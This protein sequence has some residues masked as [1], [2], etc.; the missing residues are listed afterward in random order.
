MVS[1]TRKTSG[2][3]EQEKKA[4]CVSHM[5]CGFFCCGAFTHER[6]SE[7][8]HELKCHFEMEVKEFIGFEREP[9]S[10]FA[11][12]INL[13][14][15]NDNLKRRRSADNGF[16]SNGFPILNVRL[17]GNKDDG[18]FQIARWVVD[19]IWNCNVFDSVAS[20]MHLW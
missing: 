11:S 3:I 16:L 4:R 12:I 18:T 20:A 10:V 7:S 6:C 15:F 13:G 1:P 14:A 19:D 17:T 8:G 5:S 9:R 2:G